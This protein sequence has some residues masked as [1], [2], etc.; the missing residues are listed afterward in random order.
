MARPIRGSGVKLT[1]PFVARFLGLWLVVTVV[2]VLVFS[3]TSYLLL[4]S[5]GAGQGGF[6]AVVLAVQTVCI[7]LAIG[8]LAVFTTHRL[9]GPLI[10]LQRAFDDVRAGDLERRLHLRRSDAHLVELEEAFNG[11]MDSL[12]EAGRKAS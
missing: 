11:M 6:A 1:L 8:V 9:A 7:L 3:L 2:A 4:A 5:R 10:A 12:R